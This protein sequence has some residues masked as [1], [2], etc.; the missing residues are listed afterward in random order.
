MYCS[1]VN[2]LNF[3]KRLLI[4]RFLNQIGLYA[5]LSVGIGIVGCTDSAP[6]E[7]RK[8]NVIIILAD[9]L[10]YGDISAYGNP[11]V[12]TPHLDQLSAEGVQCLQGYTSSPICSPARVGLLTGRY[13][14]RIGY[15]YNTPQR[16]ANNAVMT[17][18][19]LK[20]YLD[21]LPKVGLELAEGI[22]L[23]SDS[24]SNLPVGIPDT[25]V[26]IAE[27][28]KSNGYQTAIIGKWHVGEKDGL[29]PLDKGFDYHYG[30]YSGLSLYAPES[31]PEVVD[32]HL[33]WALSESA[34]WT[35]AGSNRIVRNDQEVEEDEYLTDRFAEEAIAFIETNQDKP[36]LLYLPFNA[37]HDPFQAKKSDFDVYANESDSTKRVYYAMIT[38]LDNA[39]GRINQR[40]KD[41]GLEE[42]TVIFFTSDN[43][44]AAYTRG[45]DNSPLK[46]G[47]LS[48]FEGGLRIP[49]FVKYPTSL[50]SGEKY[51]YP[52]SNLD[53]LPTAAA[54]AGIPL[55][56]NKEYDG[57][58][59]L[60]FLTGASKSAPH[61]LLFWRN[62]YSKAVRNGDYKL[63]VNEKSQKI[64]LYN[65]AQDPNERSDI[66]KEL[67]DL[68]S[69][70]QQS[71]KNWEGKMS[72]PNLPNRLH[73]R[74]EIDGQ[75]YYWPL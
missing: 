54:I 39:V 33:P 14:Q 17:P 25:E 46:G 31:D 4:M 58:D 26:T 47:K 36:F 65:L 34:A 41:L 74:Y 11:Y 40:L 10:G 57:V 45:T 16:L 64:H 44:G 71:L 30:F 3:N 68:V 37:P 56:T 63:Y 23:N 38:A 8:P 18:E 73:Y 21:R 9:D 60:P 22:R 6:K 1:I 66:S 12:K 35:R 5:A 24:I 42:N 67:P 69:E 13:Q 32:R 27:L 51:P 28:F 48:H 53:I 19:Q 72:T 75:I 49:F 52:V 55:P 43:G 70:L 2:A 62:G 59:L 7:Q 20:L 50:K 29:K 15:E 61:P